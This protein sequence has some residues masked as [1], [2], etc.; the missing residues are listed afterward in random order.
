MVYPHG[1]APEPP[2]PRSRS[3][4]GHVLGLFAFYAILA[5]CVLAFTFFYVFTLGGRPSSLS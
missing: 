1:H 5:S 4:S 3:G 2:E